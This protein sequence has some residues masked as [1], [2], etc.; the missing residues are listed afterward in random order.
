M[1]PTR[2][3][4]CRRRASSTCSPRSSAGARAATSGPHLARAFSFL[5]AGGG[6]LSFMLE[7]VGPGTHRLARLDADDELW[8]TGP[9]G[10]GFREPADGRRALLAGG[11]VG[12]PPLA[13]WAAALGGRR[14]G[15]ARLPRR[16][17]RRRRRAR[18]ARRRQ[19]RDR[20]RLGRPARARHRAAGGRARARPARR[21]LRLRTAGDA[22]GRARAV[23]RARRARPARARGRHGLRL[24]RLLRLRRAAARGRL[25]A[26]LHRRAGARRRPP[27]GGA[28]PH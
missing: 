2:T 12:V 25:R 27:R 3:G 16:A 5:R 23:R 24:R 22:R 14:D 10:I 6:R 1:P 21:R 26:P 28:Q 9:F 11:G 17:P 13:A 7:D 8:L 20:R 15:P 4:R 18:R 19:R